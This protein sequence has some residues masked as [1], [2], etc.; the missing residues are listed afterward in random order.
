VQG[1][2]LVGVR[3]PSSSRSV[4][5]GEVSCKPS[6]IDRVPSSGTT[7]PQEPT[8]TAGRPASRGSC[9]S[10]SSTSSRIALGVELERRRRRGRRRDHVAALERAREILTDS[11]PRL[12][13]LKVVTRRSIPRERVRADQDLRFTSGASPPRTCAR[14]SRRRRHHRP[15][16]R[17][18]RRRSGPGF[19]EHSAGAIR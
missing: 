19:D 2:A 3:D 17:S 18:A 1:R 4:N 7:A 13:R 15:A 16:S 14:T 6:G 9:N 10:P 12:L 5:N 11:R 8:A